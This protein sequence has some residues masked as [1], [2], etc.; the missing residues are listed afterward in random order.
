MKVYYFLNN[1]SKD[2]FNF[3]SE[4][5]QE[6]ESLKDIDT[7]LWKY[8]YKIWAKNDWCTQRAAF[9]EACVFIQEYV[10]DHNGSI[11]DI[12]WVHRKNFLIFN[13]DLYEYSHSKWVKMWQ[14]IMFVT[15]RD[16]W[17]HPFFSYIAKFGISRNMYLVKP[18]SYIDT[19]T[20]DKISCLFK[21]WHLRKDNIWNIVIPFL[22]NQRDIDIKNL[23]FFVRQKIGNNSILKN[24]FWVQWQNVQAV[25][26]DSY[27]SEKSS[28]TDLKEKFFNKWVYTGHCAYFTNYYEIQKEYRIYYTRNDKDIRI[29]SVK[30][31]TN[32]TKDGKSIFSQKDFTYNN[33]NITWNYCDPSH[34]LENEKKVYRVAKKIISSLDLDIWVLELCRCTDESIKFIEVNPLWWTLMHE[35]KD[36]KGIRDYYLDMW[37]NCLNLKNLTS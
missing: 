24:N 28:I 30:N 11:Y 1:L 31:R 26:S 32:E 8:V 9:V 37:K 23:L 34:F 25:K 2:D 15:S 14:N 12:E 22:M 10:N 36:E 16:S 17:K 4:K 19:S 33:L 35:G 20:K 3:F 5:I 13:E 18:N 21:V 29:Y 6:V 27:I 7:V